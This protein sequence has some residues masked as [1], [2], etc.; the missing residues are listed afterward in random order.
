[1]FIFQMLGHRS[2][3]D[4]YHVAAVNFHKNSSAIRFIKKLDANQSIKLRLDWL[5]VRPFFFDDTAINQFTSVLVNHFGR[6]LLAA[7]LPLNFGSV[8]FIAH[9]RNTRAKPHR[10]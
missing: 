9:N 1:M 2:T 3:L 8:I 7:N 6:H 10:I 4:G 5:V